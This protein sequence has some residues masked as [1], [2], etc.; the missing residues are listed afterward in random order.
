MGVGACVSPVLIDDAVL[1]YDRALSRVRS[2]LLLLN[3]A[4]ARG[5]LPLNASEVTALTASFEFEAEAELGGEAAPIGGPEGPTGALTLGLTT[6]ALE[7]PTLSIVPL[8]GEAFTRRLLAPITADTF[9]FLHHRGVGV[10]LLLR[11]LTQAAVLEPRPGQRQWL[12]HDPARPDEYFELRRRILHLDALAEAGELQVGALRL[13]ERLPGPGDAK[14]PELLSALEKGYR[15][16]G[17]E[18]E[19]LLV[20]PLAGRILLSNYDPDLRPTAERNALQARAATYPDSF[21]LVDIRPDG[22]GGGYPFQGWIKLRSFQQVI[23]FVARGIDPDWEKAVVPHPATPLVA[24]RPA[25]TLVVEEATR[26]PASATVAVE[27][28]G[29]WYW[30]PA[31]APGAQAMDDWNLRA[32]QVLTDLYH[33]TTHGAGAAPPVV[34]PVG[35][36][37]D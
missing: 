35:G 17:D 19:A 5:G 18:H 31:A 23:E 13:E 37:G 6:R 1:S 4:R 36:G 15:L 34:V 30:I 27:L 8:Q 21:L 2:E 7:A 26:A 14:L 20:R 9:E 11:L 28:H 32:F 22:P 10:G 29:R 33:L 12:R 16:A 25:R 3:V 24:A